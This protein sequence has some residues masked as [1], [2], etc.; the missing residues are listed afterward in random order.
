MVVGLR[1]EKVVGPEKIFHISATFLHLLRPIR[2]S[3]CCIGLIVIQRRGSLQPGLL[4]AK[5]L[6][7][8][9]ES[10]GSVCSEVYE[11]WQP[12]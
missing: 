4:K 1:G 8:P 12:N 11:R 9:W 3:I 10:T 5:L 6:D 2:I 7:L